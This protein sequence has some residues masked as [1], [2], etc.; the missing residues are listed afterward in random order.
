MITATSKEFLQEGNY[1]K[2]R[3]ELTPERVGQT[4]RI[5]GWE[6]KW[7]AI[8]RKLKE[9]DL[10]NVPSKMYENTLLDN[11]KFN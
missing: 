2:V 4:K 11:D 3:D 9:V 5:E 7:M 6:E 1:L 8:K 10:K